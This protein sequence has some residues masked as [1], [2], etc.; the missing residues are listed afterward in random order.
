MT[1]SMTM[2][3]S[4]D[5][6]VVG[7][8]SAGCVVAARLSEHPGNRVLLIEAG[9]DY[10]P[11]HE[12]AEILD[13]FAAT[14]YSNPDFTWPNVTARFAPRPGNAPDTRPRRVYN[15]GRVIGGTSSINGMASLRGLPSDYE[16]WAASGARGWD[17]QGV[18]PYF[19]KLE[20]DTDFDGPL[21]GK[22]GPIRLQRY[23]ADRWPGF[24]R[25]VIDAV[26]K[27]GWR[28]RKDQ[29]ADFADGYASV[30]YCHT[31]TKRMG[32]AWCY[33]TEDVRRR[34]NLAI[35]GETD[36]ENILFDGTRAIGVRARRAGRPIELRA[37]EVIVSCR[38]AALAGAAVAIRRRAG[39]R[40][41]GAGHCGRGRPAG[42]RQASDGA[43]RRQF[44]RLPEA[45]GAAAQN[46]APAD[47]RRPALFLRFRRLPAGRHVSHPVQ[48]GGLARDRRTARAHHA[49]GEPVVLDRGSED[50]R[51]RS[52]RA[53]S[54]STSTCVRTRAISSGWWRACACCAA[55]KRS[56]RCRRRWSRSSRSAS[57]TGRGGSRCISR[58]MWCKPGSAPW[59]WKPRR[60]IRR[61][62]NRQ[63]D[64]RCAQHRRARQLTTAPAA[65]GFAAPCSGIGMRHVLAGWARATTRAPSPI[66]RR[67]SMASRA[68]ALQMLPSCRRCRA[69]TP[70]F[71]PS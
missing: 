19:K 41:Y 40:P 22:D 43:S 59:R 37:R 56:P 17:W 3:E 6:I 10:A 51:R 39:A 64:R 62:D 7:A 44:R 28:D 69:P 52:D 53:G 31:D 65:N 46:T 71:R 33:L 4:W 66:R 1:A 34:P 8:G 57:A 47:V 49:V 36:V 25:G 14:A 24:A 20:T 16:H 67:A 70:T 23:S 11:G 68:C 32:A 5:F 55:C 15:Q 27:H 26:E 61:F 63:A 12:P 29:N 54:I 42:R 58:S 38:R 30:A 21:H 18:L 35:M 9:K 60:S 45:R 50:S 13:I 48:Q 2:E